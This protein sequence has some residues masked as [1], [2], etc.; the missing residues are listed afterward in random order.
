M[1]NVVCSINIREKRSRYR[2]GHSKWEVKFVIHA[3]KI[4]EESYYI[5]RFLDYRMIPQ[6]QSLDNYPRCLSEGIRHV[7]IVTYNT[8]TA[9]MD[10]FQFH[11]QVFRIVSKKDF[12]KFVNIT[13]SVAAFLESSHSH[14]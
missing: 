5:A 12:S 3:D 6:L 9:E 10:D 2:N 14:Q 11:E 1:A 8:V 7:V 13:R 4:Y